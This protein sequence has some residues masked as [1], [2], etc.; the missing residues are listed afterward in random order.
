MK[1]YTFRRLR[2]GK[3]QEVIAR[4]FLVALGKIVDEYGWLAKIGS[5]ICPECQQK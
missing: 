2:Y 1:T 5:V 4:N 3:T